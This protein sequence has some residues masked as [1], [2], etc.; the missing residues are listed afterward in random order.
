MRLPKT[1]P[2]RSVVLI[3]LLAVAGCR[4]ATPVNAIWDLVVLHGAPVHADEGGR[5]P[6]MRLDP[7]DQRVGGTT[8]CNGYSGP[9]TLKGDSLTFGALVST[10]RAC[11]DPEMNRQEAAFLA[12]LTAT[13]A[14]RVDGDTLELRDGAGAVVKLR[15]R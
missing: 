8:G 5:A 10:R 11:V 14:W 12:A 9:F 1:R 2:F 4:G 15:K 3:A 6:T 13:R 7:S